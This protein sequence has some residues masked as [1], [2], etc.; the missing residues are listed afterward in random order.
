VMTPME[1]L[2]EIWER[3][4]ACNDPDC[5]VCAR[6]KTARA[7]IVDYLNQTGREEKATE[8]VQ[9]AKRLLAEITSF[10]VELRG[11]EFYEAADKLGQAQSQLRWIIKNEETLQ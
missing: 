11:A 4:Q 9:R 3:R 6:M 10:R 2:D 7:V 5:S 8:A 1:A